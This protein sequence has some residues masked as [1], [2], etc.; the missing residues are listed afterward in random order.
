MRVDVYE[1]QD[2][3]R[4][5][6]TRTEHHGAKRRTRTKELSPRVAARPLAASVQTGGGI[7]FLIRIQFNPAPVLLCCFAAATAYGWEER[8][9]KKTSLLADWLT[10]CITAPFPA[11]KVPTPYFFGFISRDSISFFPPSQ[12]QGNSHVPIV[13]L[14]FSLSPD[15]FSFFLLFY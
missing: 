10:G 3:K 6:K 12:M 15:L 9:K 4:Q 11:N 2:K 1:R 13:Y 7:S 8:K 14:A 5:D